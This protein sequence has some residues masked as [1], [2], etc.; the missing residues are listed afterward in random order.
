MSDHIII[1]STELLNSLALAQFLDR[2]VPFS[3]SFN[4][5]IFLPSIS[6]SP[7]S[8]LN[9]KYNSSPVLYHTQNDKARL[10]GGRRHDQIHEALSR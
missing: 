3:P 1:N 8:Y 9:P 6:F 5:L 4:V 2:L 7:L 10:R